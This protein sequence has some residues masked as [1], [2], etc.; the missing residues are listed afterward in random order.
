M[1]Q[2][3]FRVRL[4]LASWASL[5]RK[6][7]L[8]DV[9]SASICRSHFPQSRSRNHRRN[10]LYSISGRDSIA[11]ANSSSLVISILQ[12]QLLQESVSV[13]ANRAAAEP[14]AA[15]PMRRLPSAAGPLAGSRD[16]RRVALN[17]V[18]NQSK[19]KK[20]C[21]RSARRL[22]ACSR[23]AWRRSGHRRAPSPPAHGAE[24]SALGGWETIPS[25]SGRKSRR[26][27]SYSKL[28][29]NQRLD[30]THSSRSGFSKA[31]VQRISLIGDRGEWREPCD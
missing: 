17:G 12:E 29:Q 16:A 15:A 22:P 23:E 21:R 20:K 18:R 5:I 7:T 9:E 30:S 6:S 2:R 28:L 11:G 4:A 26:V 19:V 27:E 14:H 8:P 24:R 1:H 10:W 3:S 25:A 31:D 13:C